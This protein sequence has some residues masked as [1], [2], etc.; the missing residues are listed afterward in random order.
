[1]QRERNNNI[2]DA[3][4]VV[5]LKAGQLPSDVFNKIKNVTDKGFVEETIEKSR[6][7][8]KSSVAGAFVGL[9]YAVYKD[10][11]VVG[12]VALFSIVFGTVGYLV[13]DYIQQRKLMNEDLLKQE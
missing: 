4:V 10:K 11:S 9:V 8:V 12:S 13:N 7:A 3:K 2:E 5:Q 6:K 1:M